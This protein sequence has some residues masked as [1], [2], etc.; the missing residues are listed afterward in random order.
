MVTDVKEE[1]RRTFGKSC[2]GEQTQRREIGFRHESI[3]VKLLFVAHDVRLTTN[4]I[5]PLKTIIKLCKYIHTFSL[6]LWTKLACFVFYFVSWFQNISL[7]IDFVSFR[8][9]FQT[10]FSQTK[11]EN[12]SRSNRSPSWC[13]SNYWGFSLRL[14]FREADRVCV[15]KCW[16]QHEG[17][18]LQS[19]QH[20][21]CYPYTEVRLLRVTNRA[22]DTC[23]FEAISACEPAPSRT[24]QHL[25]LCESLARSQSQ[26]VDS[27]QDQHTP[28]LLTSI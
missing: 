8:T 21:V 28:V 23:R 9:K 4:L 2:V 27:L 5:S 6:F 1:K 22:C 19:K 3:I 16:H 15:E 7:S 11:L 26:S 20:N 10:I 24:P 12:A 13:T 17:F 18:P 14:A 25:L